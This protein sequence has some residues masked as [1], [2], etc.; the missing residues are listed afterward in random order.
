MSYVFDFPI[1]YWITDSIYVVAKYNI[2][3]YLVNG[4]S[5]AHD[6]ANQVGLNGDALF[7]VMRSLSTLNYF[8]FDQENQTFSQTP[9]SEKMLDESIRA[10]SIFEGHPLVMRLWEN[11]EDSVVEGKSK[12][13]ELLGYPN[14]WA[15]MSNN[16]EFATIFH[17]YMSSTS[18]AFPIPSSAIDF[19]QFKTIT[20]I[21]GSNG[22]FLRQILR[23]NPHID[24]INFDIPMIHDKYHNKE[25]DQ[26]E[27][28]TRY[29]EI[30]GSAFK[31]VPSTDCYVLKSTLHNWSDI[32]VSMLHVSSGK[33]RTQKEWMNLVESSGKGTPP[34][35]IPTTTASV[36]IPKSNS[37]GYL[38]SSSSGD[39]LMS[40]A[41]YESLTGLEEAEK[42]RGGNKRNSLKMNN[43]T[44]VIGTPNSNSGFMPPPSTPSS[45]ATTATTQQ[46][47]IRIGVGNINPAAMIEEGAKEKA[48]FFT[49]IK[50]AEATDIRNSLTKFANQFVNSSIKSKPDDQGNYISTY[51][52][53]LENWILSTPLWSN[54]SETE[55][56]GIR[57]GIEKYIMQKV[58]HCTFIPAKLGG[59]EATAGNIVNENGLVPT[60]EDLQLYKHMTVMGFIE[61]HHLDIPPHFVSGSNDP[62]LSVSISEL[63]KINTYKT[64]RD[65][66]VCVYNCCKSIFKLLKDANNSGNPSGADDFLPILIFVVLKANPPMLQSNIDYITIF[67]PNRM[68][69]MI[70]CY[71]THLISATLFIKDIGSKSKLTIDSNEFER[72][73]EKSE[74]EL[75]NKLPPELLKR[76][77]YKHPL[78]I[79]VTKQSHQP[80]NNNINNS[81]QHPKISP[82]KFNVQSSSSTTSINSMN[83]SSSASNRSSNRGHTR[84][85]SIN[86][87]TTP[88]YPAHQQ[89]Q[90][91]HHQNQHHHHQSHH[92]LIFTADLEDFD[93]LSIDHTDTFG[94]EL[95]RK[96]EFINVQAEDIRIGQLPKL[97]ED[98][99]RLVLENNLL[100]SKINFYSSEPTSLSSS[101]ALSRMPSWTSSSPNLSSSPVTTTTA[102]NTT[103]TST[104]IPP[105]S[106]TKTTT[107]TPNPNPNTSNLDNH[108]PIEF[109]VDNNTNNNNNNITTSNNINNSSDIEEKSAITISTNLETKMSNSS[110]T[111][112]LD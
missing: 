90:H 9:L 97:L 92:Q 16:K 73:K 28:G 35:P 46:D 7:R 98:Y 23:T 65:K 70:G 59:L 107:T 74:L 99:K 25:K 101:P 34:T 109:T 104:S 41:S 100:K 61:P 11:F 83:N 48:N 22:E 14:F 95:E 32:E 45:S 1:G 6:I 79:P 110:N 96:Y 85:L 55:I 40:S 62:R 86:S 43:S 38:K 64:P 50:S 33:Q 94:Y 88:P 18:K 82:P 5:T 2:S 67:S 63:R 84:H 71:F 19:S 60:D 39:D 75:P 37:S 87:N 69:T 15:L 21:G 44:I 47:T 53:E 108:N 30:P 27:F 29:K 91:H 78:P 20:D 93:S 36:D 49:K 31:E 112:L 26:K 81:H 80:Q 17:S 4:P 13:S 57:D 24:G 106:P 68:S 58:F 105:T 51:S 8:K 77:N 89:P 42:Q 54:A 52:R 10:G 102:T 76:L 111:S 72:L 3:K 56:E 103:S 12:G 66:M